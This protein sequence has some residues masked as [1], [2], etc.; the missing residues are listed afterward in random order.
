MVAAVQHQFTHPA[1]FPRPGS[2]PSKVVLRLRYRLLQAHLRIL[3]GRLLH[4]SPPPPPRCSCPPHAPACAPGPCADPSHLD[5]P[6]IWVVRVLPIIV[7]AYLRPL[8]RE[9]AWLLAV[10]L[11]SVGFDFAA[12]QKVQEL[13]LNWFVVEQLPR[14]ISAYSNTGRKATGFSAPAEALNGLTRVASSRKLMR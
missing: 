13:H 6:R 9:H 1:L 2:D 14:R 12:R 7:A 5:D 8:Y 4:P 3:S 10:C 11:N